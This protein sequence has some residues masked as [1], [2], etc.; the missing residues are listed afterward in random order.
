MK[1]VPLS[2]QGMHDHRLQPSAS[3]VFVTR[4]SEPSTLSTEDLSMVVSLHETSDGE[5]I[6][7][8]PTHHIHLKQGKKLLDFYILKASVQ[9]QK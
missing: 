7:T 6:A 4:V 5:V 9:E 2:N 3:N 8:T 1:K